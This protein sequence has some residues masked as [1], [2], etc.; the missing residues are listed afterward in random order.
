M[1]QSVI[2]FSL[3]CA[4]LVS[5]LLVSASSRLCLSDNNQQSAIIS[6]T[7]TIYL[8]QYTTYKLLRH[9]DTFEKNKEYK[10]IPVP[11][12]AHFYVSEQSTDV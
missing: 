7:V 6:I 10:D 2:I 4:L 1:I 3:D 11:D 8:V 5:V 12:S 9:D